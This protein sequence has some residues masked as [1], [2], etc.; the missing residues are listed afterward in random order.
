M[1]L[2]V[3][4]LDSKG[5]PVADLTAADFRVS[6]DGKEKP[7]IAFR[8]PSEKPA[9]ETPPAETVILYD[10]LNSGYSH[11]DYDMTF[12]DRALEPL[13]VADNVYLYFLTNHGVI[14]PIHGFP[15]RT[16]WLFIPAA[17]AGCARIP[18]AAAPW[19]RQIHA[20]LDQGV[21][22]VYGFRTADSPTRDTAR[23]QRSRR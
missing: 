1:I 11:R 8:S 6:D 14:Y 12:I 2:T 16:K 15:P 22:K 3:T 17:R 4:A 20:L 19:T 13:E 23:P 9:A 7:R 5:D 10:L 21:Q 18:V